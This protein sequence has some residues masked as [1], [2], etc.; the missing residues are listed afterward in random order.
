M[1]WNESTVAVVMRRKVSFVQIPFYQ[2]DAFTSRA[3]GGNPAAVMPLV[4]WLPDATLQAIAVE[5][6]LSETAFFVPSITG[7][8][9]HLRWFTPTFEIDLCGHATLA[10][11]A[12]IFGHLRPELSEVTFDSMSGRLVVRRDGSL[13][14]LD[15]PSR[16][17]LAEEAPSPELLAALGVPV[18]TVL[19]S[20]EPMA[21]LA[22]ADLVRDLRPNLQA[23]SQIG[24]GAVTVTASDGDAGYVC[25]LFA[26]GI[27]IPEDPVTGA[28]Q[29][30]LGPYWAAR[31]GR[32]DLQV[33]QLS[34]RGGELRVVVDGD[35]VR[36]AGEAVDV[37][38]G[39]FTITE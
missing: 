29:T 7:S 1:L 25:R 30:T 12:I 2:V 20:R 31:L 4:S 39:T 37:I 38:H 27:G 18:E 5:N 3:F 16:P 10:T 17:S 24:G 13:L 14:E 33:R 8:D 28:I 19:V 23:I 32:N 26:P 36:I 9:Y 35:R 11:A 6:N 22:S 15:F 21:V 34:Q